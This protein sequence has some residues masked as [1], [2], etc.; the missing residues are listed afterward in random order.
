MESQLGAKPVTT[1]TENG[2]QIKFEMDAEEAKNF[3]GS[4]NAKVSKKEVIETFKKQ[5]NECK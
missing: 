5:G 4:N 2:A 3:T 1:E